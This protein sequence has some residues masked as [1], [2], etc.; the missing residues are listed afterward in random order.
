MAG[1]QRRKEDE[2]EQATVFCHVFWGEESL[3]WFVQVGQVG[4]KVRILVQCQGI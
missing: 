4:G 1:G 2:G 3:S